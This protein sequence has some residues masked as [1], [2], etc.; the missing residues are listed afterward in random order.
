MSSNAGFVVTR[1][2]QRFAEFCDACRKRRYIGLC[3]GSPG[4]GKTLSA[5][6]YTNWD[7]LKVSQTL[8][9][10]PW[11]QDSKQSTQLLREGNTVYY[12][13]TTVNTPSGI[14]KDI[15]QARLSLQE[16]QKKK[17]HDTFE[18]ELKE[19][20]HR[21]AIEE[22]SFR[23]NQRY[24][25]LGMTRPQSL[26]AAEREY[27]DLR[28]RLTKS[29]MRVPDPT[30]L[31]IIDE[32]DRLKMSSLEQVRDL[33]DR[34]SFGLI[35]VGM[36]GIEK[37]LARYPQL[38]S[39]VGFV[40]EFCPLSSDDVRELLSNWRPEGVRLPDA[41][42]SDEEGVASIIRTVN[43]NFR[44]LNRLLTQIARILEIND[45]DK[46]TTAVVNAARES[47]VIGAA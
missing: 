19:A 16:W 26:E 39:R 11:D 23:Q 28:N 22:E 1:E 10:D 46:V 12:V 38:Y 42:L 25:Y 2:Y 14:T 17:V 5:R 30:E 27:L 34:D 44:L 31:I 8:M 7:H 43:G 37:R 3:F 18:A 6:Q 21:L 13:P 20:R 4:V 45:L 9:T 33:F 47:L 36:P 32:A 24:M 15:V 41:G 29:L 35:L 40:H